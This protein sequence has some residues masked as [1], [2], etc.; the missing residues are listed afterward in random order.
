MRGI[1]LI[2]WDSDGKSETVYVSQTQYL[3]FCLLKLGQKKRG[4][5][6]AL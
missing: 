1:I 5:S 2:R 4:K 6:N 3:D